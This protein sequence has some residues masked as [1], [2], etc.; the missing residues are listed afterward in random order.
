[1][2]SNKNY[3][4]NRNC[5]ILTP[6]KRSPRIEG[7]YGREPT[8]FELKYRESRVGFDFRNKKSYYDIDEEG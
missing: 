8:I 7:K 1:L 4:K 5:D 2:K 6:L 3:E